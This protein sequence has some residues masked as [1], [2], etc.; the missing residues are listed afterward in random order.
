MV[1]I[2]PI[3]L[4][5]TLFTIGCKKKSDSTAPPVTPTINFRGMTWFDNFGN[6]MYYHDS[7]DWTISDKW[8]AT[9]SGLFSKSYSTNCTPQFKYRFSPYPNPFHDFFYL[10]INQSPTAKCEMKIVDKHYH[11]ILSVDSVQKSTTIQSPAFANKDTLRIYYR[12]LDGQ[13]EYRGHGDILPQ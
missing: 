6:I 4:L 13:C 7:T 1:R 12:F 5:L 10:S 9:E 3:I 8:N 2:V 11:I